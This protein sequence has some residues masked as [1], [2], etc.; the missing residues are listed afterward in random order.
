MSRYRV[1]VLSAVVLLVLAETATILCADLGPDIVTTVLTIVGTVV[2]LGLLALLLV[3]KSDWVFR[4][5]V[6]IPVAAYLAF[7]LWVL[8]EFL[9]QVD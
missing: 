5:I 6:F 7:K 8:F 4:A 9:T 1:C 3:R 2:I